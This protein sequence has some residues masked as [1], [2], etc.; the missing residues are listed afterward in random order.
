MLSKESQY[1]NIEY[2]SSVKLS[3]NRSFFETAPD[4]WLEALAEQK[5][6]NTNADL[7]LIL[8]LIRDQLTTSHYAFEIG[9]GFGRVIE[10]IRKLAP[11][12]KIVAIDHSSKFNDLVR[13]KFQGS[14]TLLNKSIES[15]K[16]NVKIDLALWMWAGIFELDNSNKFS[17]FRNI[18]DA[19]YENGLL[20]VE[21]PENIVGHNIEE[22]AE[23]NSLI[24]NTEFGTLNIYRTN[25]L[26]LEDCAKKCGFDLVK[27]I[28][29]S[30]QVGVLR[31]ILIFK[32]C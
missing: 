26:D 20:V 4:G 17:A 5:G 25:A 9:F 19:M 15:F 22:C 14:V 3:P 6:L 27:D 12:K 18:S 31:R 13:N 10:W 32:K 7:E 30:P 21:F 24:V 11:A 1:Q 23:K 8:P 29:Y 16:L 2:C 28:V